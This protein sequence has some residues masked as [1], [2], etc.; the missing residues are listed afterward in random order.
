[1]K[2]GPSNSTQP[3]VLNNNTIHKDSEQAAKGVQVSKPTA[4]KVSGEDARMIEILAVEINPKIDQ[5][6]IEELREKIR[7]IDI[8]VEE[9]AKNIVKE[10]QS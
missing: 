1:M 8:D 6:M 9:I 5:A 7:N 3:I 2:V 4:G 10:Y